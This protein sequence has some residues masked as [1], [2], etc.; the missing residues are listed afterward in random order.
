[1]T[2]NFVW[3][4]VSKKSLHIRDAESK[5]YQTILNNTKEIQKFAEWLSESAIVVYEPTGVY[6]KNLAKSFNDLWVNYF[7]IHAN[8]IKHLA[9]SLGYKN[10]TDKL[11]CKMI[12]EVSETIANR[13]SQSGKKIFTR[14]N[15]NNINQILEYLSQIET[16][17]HQIKLVKQSN[18]K[19]QNTPYD[20]SF[21]EE[22]NKKLLKDLQS[23]IARLEKDIENLLEKDENTKG[24]VEKMKTIPW[25]WVVASINLVTF[26]Q[27]LV[28][29][30]MKQVD[31]NQMIAYTWFNPIEH[32]SGNMNGSYLSKKWDSKIRDSVYLS[33]IQWMKLVKLDKYK[34]TTIGK[35][36]VRMQNKFWSPSNKRWKSVACAVCKKILTIAWAIF[37]NNSEYQYI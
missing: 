4:D 36:T 12:A 34:D 35:F 6:W 14:P 18:E 19:M 25:I 31:T 27:K 5:K 17:K 37:R 1:M 16:Y 3:I 13:E 23:V 32:S 21:A 30:G 11:D 15:S 29:K 9:E 20:S 8:K 10:K 26:F 2:T 7:E 24:K 28:E 22:T 33:G